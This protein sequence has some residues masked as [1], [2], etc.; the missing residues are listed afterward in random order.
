M[1]KRHGRNGLVQKVESI[2]IVGLSVVDFNFHFTL[3]REFNAVF[4]LWN[5]KLNFIEFELRIRC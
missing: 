4:L 5:F 2:R 3:N 1:C